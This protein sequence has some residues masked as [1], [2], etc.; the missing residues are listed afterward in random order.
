MDK[1]VL[2]VDYK[3]G[4]EFTSICDAVKGAVDGDTVLLRLGRYDE[5]VT[6]DKNI[7][8]VS[9]EGA[10]QGDVIITG[11]V[12]VAANATLRNISVQQSI[13]IRSGDPKILNCDVSRGA[14][15]IRVGRD[16]N[17]SI[18]G[19]RIHDAQSG[20][21]GVYFQEGAKGT[22]EN[23]DIFACRVNGIHVNA[24]DVTLRRNRI[25]SCAYGIYF[26]KG[27]RGVVEQNQL[28][29]ISCFGIYVVSRSDPTVVKNSVVGME[30]ATAGE[31]T[32]H[33][34]MISAE[35]AGN[36][37]DNVV[38]NAS[39]R[40]LKGCVPTFGVNDF[41]RDKVY[42]ENNSAGMA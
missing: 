31:R 5:K 3:G 30:G 6:V 10:D 35:G 24:A 42:N 32:I 18:V 33:A 12:V 37:Q 16:C 8:I 38:S 20:G 1:R 26:R 27:A 11:G 22:V 39:V 34:I 36:F 29:L 7:E 15:G 2:V 13:D 9:E 19:C 25:E 17:P 23:C 21:D 4:S 14:D 40:V 28:R 41:V